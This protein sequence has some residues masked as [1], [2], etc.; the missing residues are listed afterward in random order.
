MRGEEMKHAKD[1]DVPLILIVDDNPI[2]LNVLGNILQPSFKNI[3]VAT[4][5]LQAL[6]FAAAERPDLVLLDVMM[7]DLDGIETCL[8]LKA[9]P[10]TADIP[11]IFLTARIEPDDIVRGFEVGAVDYV[12][13][14]FNP[15]E[16]LARVNTHLELARSI[17]ALERVNG[18]RKEMLHV[19]SHD[20]AN[21][22]NAIRGFLEISDTPGSL[23]DSRE[24][25]MRAAESAIGIINMVRTMQA[26]EERKLRLEPVNII[27]AI[28]ESA[29]MLALSSEKKGVRIELPSGPAVMILAEKVSLVNSVINNLLTNAIK[30]S[31]PGGLIRV[32]VVAGDGQIRAV[33]S[34]SGIGMP[35]ELLR[36]LFD[37]RKATS[38]TGTAGESGTGFGMPLVKR[39]MESY[40]GGISVASS[41]IVAAPDAHGT[42]VTLVF[43]LAG[44][45]GG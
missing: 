38:R 37:I 6:E 39:F 32:S 20:L 41:D 3:A 27:G 43:K 17:R 2:N 9:D 11:V 25:L 10:R 1:D 12:A 23:M 35:S 13:K 21:P 22:L 30:F 14:P 16:L 45:S 33:I 34:D 18:T 26:T 42:E 28:R 7:P 29:S 24:Y 15:H 44:N 40:G 36:D 5:G 8:R 4:G 31:A 19:L